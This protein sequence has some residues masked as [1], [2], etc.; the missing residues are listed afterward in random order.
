MVIVAGSAAAL[1]ADMAV[2]DAERVLQ[3]RLDEDLLQAELRNAFARQP[4]NRRRRALLLD[5]IG[6]KQRLQRIEVPAG[7]ES[8]VAPF[9]WQFVAGDGLLEGEIADRGTGGA[10]QEGTVLILVVIGEVELF[11]VGMR[12]MRQQRKAV[13]EGE[14]RIQ[15]DRGIPCPCGR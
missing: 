1:K 4:A 14:I 9:A 10:I 6:R 8:V 15:R 5:P 11:P 7:V 2:G 13:H 12:Q 3:M